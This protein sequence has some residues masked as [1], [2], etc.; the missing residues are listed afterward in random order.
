M[1]SA[2][3][4]PGSGDQPGVGLHRCFSAETAGPVGVAS[5][6]GLQSTLREM[7]VLKINGLVRLHNR[8]KPALSLGFKLLILFARNFLSVLY[9]PFPEAT[10]DCPW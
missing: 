3:V 9:C 4:Q 6:N 10:P 1:N 2:T 5:E 7:H 8:D